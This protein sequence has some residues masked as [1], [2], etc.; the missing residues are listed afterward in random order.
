MC[1]CIRTCMQVCMHVCTYNCMCISYY[2]RNTYIL[3]LFIML[4]I[5]TIIPPITFTRWEIGYN[6]SIKLVRLLSSCEN[7]LHSGRQTELSSA[8]SNCLVQFGG[9]VS[10]NPWQSISS[11]DMLLTS[12]ILHSAEHLFCLTCVHKSSLSLASAYLSGPLL[13]WFKA[14]QNDRYVLLVQ[15]GFV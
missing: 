10:L 2:I 6:P 15:N 14:L 5:M 3:V 9:L 11:S 7:S 12:S 8:R 4:A 13:Q 1:T